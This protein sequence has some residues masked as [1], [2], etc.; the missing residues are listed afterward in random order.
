MNFSFGSQFW[1]P[2]LIT[3]FRLCAGPFVV[4]SLLQN[5]CTF[6]LIIFFLAGLSDWLDGIVARLMKSETS[7]GRLF[8]PIADKFFVACVFLFCMYA[9]P[10][11]FFN[12]GVFILARDAMILFGAYILRKKNKNVALKPIYISKINTFFVLLYLFYFLCSS[13]YYSD[14]SQSLSQAI[15]T[16][17]KDLTKFLGMENTFFLYRR[18]LII[19]VTLHYSS[20][21]TTI[22][23]GIIYVYVFLKLYKS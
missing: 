13:A 23:S 3:G 22:V 19:G 18:L 6:A 7:F 20:L 16:P 2:Q 8:D 10:G 1:I 11:I 5:K 9:Y 14:F 21:I 12:M 17:L 4:L 15:S